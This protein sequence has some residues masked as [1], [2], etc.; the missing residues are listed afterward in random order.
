MY[1]GFNIDEN[2]NNIINDFNFLEKTYIFNKKIKKV[3]EIRF[4]KIPNY[5]YP[6]SKGNR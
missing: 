2:T 3:L 1:L 5:Y 4:A 6:L